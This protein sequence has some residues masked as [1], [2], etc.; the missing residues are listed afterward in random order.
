MD[1][2]YNYWTRTCSVILVS[3]NSTF[4]GPLTILGT[5]AYFQL[6]VIDPRVRVKSGAEMW[7]L[8]LYMCMYMYVQG[9]IP[10]EEE[11]EEL[12]SMTAPLLNAVPP[13]EDVVIIDE[14]QQRGMIKE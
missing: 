6:F 9:L 11:Q 7:F 4:L 10:D 2:L 1:T 12:V 8:Y 5:H 3:L 14:M 13:E